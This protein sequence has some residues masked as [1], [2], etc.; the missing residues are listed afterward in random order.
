MSSFVT[1]ILPVVPNTDSSLSSKV[2]PTYSEITVDPVRIAIS[3]RIALRLSPN[4]GA[5]TAQTCNP[6]WI[7]F[8]IK[9]VNGSVS[10]SSAII[11][12]GLFFFSAY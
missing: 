1:S 9:F 6:P 10:I 3:F 2:I 7:L 4:D 11:N 8:T 12:N 5:L